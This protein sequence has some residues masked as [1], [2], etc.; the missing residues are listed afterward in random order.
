M[1][2]K[3]KVNGKCSDCVLEG[4]VLDFAVVV[5]GGCGLTG[6]GDVL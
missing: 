3:W 6:E 1:G 5:D 2:M 4:V